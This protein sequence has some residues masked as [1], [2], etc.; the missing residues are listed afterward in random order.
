MYAFVW[1][2]Y[3]RSNKVIDIFITSMWSE[4]NVFMNSTNMI[5]EKIKNS[6]EIG[7]ILLYSLTKIVAFTR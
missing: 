2:E 1:I 7:F 6:G 3:L 4:K 5:R